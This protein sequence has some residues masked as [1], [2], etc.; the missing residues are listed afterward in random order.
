VIGHSSYVDHALLTLLVVAAASGYAAGWATTRRRQLGRL[1]AAGG[2]AVMLIAATSPPFERLADRSF[3]WHMVQHLVLLAVVAPAIVAARPVATLSEASTA[4]HHWRTSLP[5]RTLR[6]T[7][8]AART[9]VALVI[10]LAVHVGDAYD[11]AL[12]HRLAHDAQHLAFVVAGC[13]MWS[14]S[15]EP[16]VRRAPERIA[17]AFAGSATLTVLSLWLLALDS[18]LSAHYTARVGAEAA[19]DDQRTGAGVMWVGMISLTLPLLLVA[20]WQWAATEQ[21]VAERTEAILDGRSN[22]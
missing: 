7:G 21:R 18:P 4:A 17:A 20:V 12:D 19:L 6:R 15:L 3:A 22:Q 9:A 13:L 5:A 11:A 14:I 1:V 2:A 16:A 8:I 10:L